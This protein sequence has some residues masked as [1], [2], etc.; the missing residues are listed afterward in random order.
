[1]NL[2]ANKRC[3]MIDNDDENGYV[4][5]FHCRSLLQNWVNSYDI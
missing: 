1:M 3:I 2:Q 5:K 4:G